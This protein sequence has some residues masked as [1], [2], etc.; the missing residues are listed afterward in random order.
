ML[1]A[2]LSLYCE[3]RGWKN[4][5]LSISCLKCFQKH[6]V[7]FHSCT[8][9][10]VI[11]QPPW[12]FLFQTRRR[13]KT[14]HCPT[15]RPSPISRSVHWCGTLHSG[16]CR[17]S[18]FF[19]K[20]KYHRTLSMLFFGHVEPVFNFI[21]HLS[22]TKQPSFRA[23]FPAVKYF[24]KWISNCLPKVKAIKKL[25]PTASDLLAPFLSLV[26]WFC[27]LLLP[28]SDP[29]HHTVLPPP[30]QCAWQI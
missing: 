18:K 7:V 23:I 11:S 30:P 29:F 15:L 9:L 27:T 13:A 19:S 26:D 28:S 2:I 4:S 12:C 21:W 14:M 16:C 3:N 8:I 5:S 17:F 10:F 20:S 22:S 6:I 24:F 25:M 1:A